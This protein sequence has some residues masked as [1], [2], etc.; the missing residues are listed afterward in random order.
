VAIDPGPSHDEIRIGEQ[1]APEAGVPW[2]PSHRERAELRDPRDT[3]A[4]WNGHDF[5]Q[6]EAGQDETTSH[7]MKRE[8]HLRELSICFEE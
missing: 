7:K 6:A 5:P 8:K 4:K 1:I 2:S 3:K